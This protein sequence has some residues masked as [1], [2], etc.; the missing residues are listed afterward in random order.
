MHTQ[1]RHVKRSVMR[2]SD[3]DDVD[4]EAIKK[5]MVAVSKAKYLE[6][7]HYDRFLNARAFSSCSYSRW[8][9]LFDL[10]SLLTLLN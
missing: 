3:D 10:F 7:F 9:S 2:A 6:Y 8:V 4:K 5:H 1:H